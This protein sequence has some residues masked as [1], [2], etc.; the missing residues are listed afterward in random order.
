M[1]KILRY[2]QLDSFCKLKCFLL[3]FIAPTSGPLITALSD[4][5]DGRSNMSSSHPVVILPETS[6]ITSKP[7]VTSP[8]SSTSG[9]YNTSFL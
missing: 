7:I 5:D 1:V 3:I 6:N 9:K 4:D 2:K 8:H